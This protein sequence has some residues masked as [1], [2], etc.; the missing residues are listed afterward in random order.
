MSTFNKVNENSLLF[1]FQYV[2][3]CSA[4]DMPE[5]KWNILNFGYGVNFKYEGMLSHSFDRFYVVKNFELSKVEDLH[6]T[7]VQFD[8][9]CSYLKVEKDKDNI[10]SSYLP[11]LLAYSEKNFTLCNFYKKQIAYYNCTAYEMLTNEIGLIL[12]AFPKEKSHKRSTIGSIISGFIG[13]AY[14]G[15]SSFL[16][17]KHQKAL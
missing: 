16:H 13:L 5:L 8:S 6:L 15:I 11:N 12:P 14:E 3:G 10:A 7:T 17:H 9:T 2:Y 1:D 4:V